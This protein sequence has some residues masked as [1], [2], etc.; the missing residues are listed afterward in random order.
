MTLTWRDDAPPNLVKLAVGRCLIDVMDVSKWTELGLLTDTS[1]Q[2]DAHPRLLRSLRFDDDD[3][4]GHVL[5]FVPALL[6]ETKP[7]AAPVDPWADPPAPPAPTLAERFP[8]LDT[9]A[10][11]IDLPAWLALSDEKLFHRLLADTSDTDSTLPDGTVLSAAESAAARLEVGEMRR[12][13]ERIRRDHATDPEATIGQAK[14]LIETVCRTILGLTGDTTGSEPLKL[15]ALVKRTMLHLG[16][17]PTQV[18]QQTNDA[19][20]ARIAKQILG[21]IAS[22]LQAADELRNARGTGHGR[23]GAPLIDDALARMSVGVVLASVVYL[24]E[25]FESRTGAGAK[26][27]LVGGPEAAPPSQRPSAPL[28][29]SQVVRH[30]TFGEGQITALEGAGDTLTADIEFGTGTGSKRLLVRYAKLEPVT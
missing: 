2:I 26:P 30:P 11:F 5:D 20:Q 18:D 6:H 1:D 25:V 8:N 9:V 13:V 3:Y 14:D 12:Q 15:H 4:A 27:V 19:V 22:L 16:I 23:S 7:K 24:T 10:D 28:T 29:V 17:D 21:G